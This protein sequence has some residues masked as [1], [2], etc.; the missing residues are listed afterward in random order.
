MLTIR[1]SISVTPRRKYGAILQKLLANSS[2]GGS[3]SQSTNP[4]A[5]ILSRKKQES[6]DPFISDATQTDA[7]Q[8]D[9]S[10]STPA[11]VAEAMP[12]PLGVSQAASSAS[13]RELSDAKLFAAS[14]AL[15]VGDASQAEQHLQAAKQYR[16]TYST[17]DDSPEK[18]AQS[19]AEYQQLAA[20]KDDSPSWR[21]G[22]TKYLIS[23]ANSLLLWNDL[24]GAERTANE[25]ATLSS[26]LSIEGASPIDVLA[27]IA[28]MRAGTFEPTSVNTAP[29]S[30]AEAKTQTL[31]LLAA[32]RQAM[33]A[34]N[35][36]QAEKLAGQASQLGV[37][38]SQF[39]S[40]EDR[41]SQLAADVQRAQIEQQQVILTNNSEPLALR[42]PNASL[43]STPR[44]AQAKI[45][46]SP[47]PAPTETTTP[48]ASPLE[49]IEQGET[50]L[51]NG[52][53][54]GALSLFQSGSISSEISSTLSAR[55]SFK[56]IFRCCRPISTFKPAGSGWFATRHSVA[57]TIG[58]CAATFR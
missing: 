39:A 14:P 43:D 31:Q 20:S 26:D 41:P 5:A 52:D 10:L 48:S 37:A 22:Y 4:L 50:A 56:T 3:E 24:D 29:D 51:R 21:Q 34:G 9:S 19:I 2:G 1:F 30:I 47:L 42:L 40:H 58:D 33:A 32:A 8:Q 6:T 49:L 55:K 17:A 23:Q 28:Q 46:P 36:P 54:Q 57:R 7:P 38:D 25:A 18:I 44:L 27:R 45:V 13:P 35:L 12:L 53:R 16:V 15:A 11:T